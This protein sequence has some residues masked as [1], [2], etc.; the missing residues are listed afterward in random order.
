MGWCGARGHDVA[1]CRPPCLVLAASLPR[2]L[3][4]SPYQFVRKEIA[5][6]L[7]S[8]SSLS[9]KRSGVRIPS[10]LP[11]A[12]VI[13]L[14]RRAY[15]GQAAF[16]LWRPLPYRPLPFRGFAEC[17]ERRRSATSLFERPALRVSLDHPSGAPSTFSLQVEAA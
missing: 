13:G 6:P 7:L 17:G 3:T 16:L 1:A 15:C 11:K 4:R 2:V 14:S 8:T 9:R 12:V 10:G 5:R